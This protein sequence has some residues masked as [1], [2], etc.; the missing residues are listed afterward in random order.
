MAFLLKTAQIH[1][2]KTMTV[3]RY[4]PNS[5][6][7]DI[8]FSPDGK[9]VKYEDYEILAEENVRLREALRNVADCDTSWEDATNLAEAAL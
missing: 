6:Q 9:Y 8:W 1:R 7:G 5:L 3:K 4:N 2:G